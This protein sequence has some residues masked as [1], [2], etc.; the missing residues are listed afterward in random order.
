MPTYT[1][2]NRITKES[3]Q[4]DAPCAQDACQLLGWMIGNCHVQ[5]V[6]WGM[7]WTRVP[8]ATEHEEQ[9]PAARR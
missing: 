7:T 8:K 5:I 4:V 3:A 6:A 1:V 9:D 2:T